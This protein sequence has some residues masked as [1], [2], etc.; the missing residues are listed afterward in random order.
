MVVCK[1][2]ATS[3]TLRAEADGVTD[4]ATIGTDHDDAQNHDQV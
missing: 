1:L 4:G 3:F 2:H